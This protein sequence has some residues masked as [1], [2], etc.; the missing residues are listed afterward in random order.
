MPEGCR[1]S[2][3]ERLFHHGS[4]AAVQD[5]WVIARVS[6]EQLQYG[7]VCYLAIST[8]RYVNVSSKT[9]Q[10]KSFSIPCAQMLRMHRK[11]DATTLYHLYQMS[12]DQQQTTESRDIPKIHVRIA[13]LPRKSLVVCGTV[14]S[15]ST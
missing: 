12:M 5:A 6:G 10:V 8:E 3:C 2:C 15:V 7:H 4:V 11:P 14:G 9:I 1:S 13:S